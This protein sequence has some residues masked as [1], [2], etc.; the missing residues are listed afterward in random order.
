MQYPN[1]YSLFAERVAQF[2]ARDD[3]PRNVFYFRKEDQWQGISWD[4][5]DEEA[6][7]FAIALL[8]MG[9]PAGA[10]V[11]I[12]MGNVPEWPISDLGTIMAGGVGVGL[13]PSS[14]AEQC[15]YIIRHSGSEFLL[16]D[17]AA[18]L[19]KV[20]SIRDRLPKLR[21]IIALD[22]PVNAG[23]SGVISY[24]E[25]INRGR[26][27]GEFF[28]S[29]LRQRSEGAQADDIAIM[30]YTSGTT[31]P[32]KGACLSHRYI[33]NSVESLRQTIPLFETD[34]SFS[35]L[36]FCHVAERI[37]G[38]YNRLYSGVSAYFVDNLSRLGEYMLD[39]KPTVFASL[40]RF[41]EKIHARIVADL[42]LV[43][44][45][46]RMAFEDALVLGRQISKLRQAREAVPDSL[47]EEFL[48][49]A[50]ALHRLKDYFGGRIRLATSGSA[51][52]PIEVAEFFDACGLPIL[53][54]YG[55]T[56]NI[57]VAFNRPDNH[58]F[59]TVGPP[60]PGCE[61]KIAADGEILVHSE[62]MFSG[63]Y[64]APEQTAE[65]F[66]DGWLV[67][68]D[69]GELDADGFLKITGRKKELIVTSTG[70]KVAPALIENMLKEHH[71]ISQAMV[72]GEGKSYLV[73]L[74]T[75]NPIEAGEY[76][77]AHGVEESP[78]GL[79]AS[80]QILALVK[81]MV[82]QVNARVSS[83][84]SIKRFV[85]LE[86]DFEIEQDEITPTGKIKRDVVN[87]RYSELIQCLYEET[88]ST[89]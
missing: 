81:G 61:V 55:L 56:E 6:R 33:L 43:N 12:L 65:M 52:L 66:R 73:A 34:V 49:K 89:K 22:A 10:S 27:A 71:L 18:Q 54:A 58:K 29:L 48:K 26:A 76:A 3:A 21:T 86:R 53:Q 77:R 17:T 2:R 72:Y 19:A 11:A 1:I 87:R 36:P 20:L 82:D 74:L 51:P 13:Y 47:Q 78:S 16:V 25:F 15:E 40:P 4:R 24:K 14:S 45:E 50:P 64:Q 88:R 31:G 63:Y 38:L 57:C 60:M 8:S 70:K 37:S 59:G 46:E 9:L 85:V 44:E 23:D 7:N 35:Y 28:E 75:L 5:F 42:D 68:G 32:P 83:T 39:V 30:V 67:T 80:D 62:M 69:I 84:E 41:F 79:T